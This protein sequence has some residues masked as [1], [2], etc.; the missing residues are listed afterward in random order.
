MPV[1]VA[2]SSVISDPVTSRYAIAS[3]K[4]GVPTSFPNSNFHLTEQTARVFTR[5]P[6]WNGSS[7]R[8]IAVGTQ[9]KITSSNRMVKSKVRQ[10]G[11]TLGPKA[12]SLLDGQLDDAIGPWVGGFGLDEQKRMRRLSGNGNS[13][14]RIDL[15]RIISSITY[16]DVHTLG[17][18]L[19][20]AALSWTN[21]PSIDTTPLPNAPSAFSSATVGP[22]LH[23][24]SFHDRI[25]KTLGRKQKNA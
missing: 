6:T 17:R 7:K 16:T 11:F 21:H 9:E 20:A 3:R 24:L 15:G 8:N 2:W 1:N 18:P 13:G 25:T 22:W 19:S 23:F 12:R 5:T 4:W 10:M 14:R